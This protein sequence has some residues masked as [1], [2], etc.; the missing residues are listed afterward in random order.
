MKKFKSDIINHQSGQISSPYSE[1][2]DFYEYTTSNGMECVFYR[3][4]TNPI[5]NLTIGYKV[6]S[7]D[8]PQGK[9]GIAH[10]FEHLM[11]Q[12][13]ENVPRGAH[14]QFIQDMGGLCNA[15]TMQDLT[16]YFDIA[17]SN[18]LETI[19]WLESDRMNALDL[20]NENLDNQKGVVIEEKK[21]RYEN[22][23]YG[24]AFHN[25]FKLVMQ[26]SQYQ[27]PVIGFEDDIHSF[28]LQEAIDFHK[29]YY[30]PQN[31]VLVLSGDFEI[32]N[33]KKL[34]EKY[35]GGIENKPIPP[36]IS[37]NIHP[38]EGDIHTKSYDDVYLPVIYFAYQ[39]PKSGTDEDYTLDYFANILAND[40][41]SRLHKKL[42]YD[43]LIA[44]SVHAVKYQLQD[45][46]IFI[47]RVE[48]LSN[49]NIDEVEKLVTDEIENVIKYGFSDYEYEK[50]RNGLEFSNTTSITTLQKIGLETLFNKV[51]FNDVDLINRKVKN[52][53]SYTKDDIIGSAKEYFEDK[54]KFV[55]KYLPNNVNGS[56]DN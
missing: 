25:M 14:F 49:G 23:P 42:I 37:N 16:V 45:A 50:I 33:A 43:M 26:G 55:M 51:L 11:F 39:I 15:F 8:E 41:S 32:D 18:Q 47:L 53:L 28:S 19:L 35:F 34:I 17:P 20:T 24:M 21:Q 2:L 3:D 38:M 40:E 22:A 10:L 31:A 44:K 54:Y 12:G 46:G 36:R 30:S 7:K 29:S 27:D 48:L 56:G 13:S 6:G 1:K 9:K 4:N 52:Y 5:V